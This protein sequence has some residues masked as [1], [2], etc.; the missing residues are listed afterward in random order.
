MKRLILLSFLFIALYPSSFKAQIVNDP[1]PPSN[2][3]FRQLESCPPGC[4]TCSSSEI[5][6]N[7]DTHRT[8]IDGKCRCEPPRILIS[9]NCECPWYMTGNPMT[10]DC[11][12]I[13]LLDVAYQPNISPLFDAVFQAQINPKLKWTAPP[14]FTWTFDCN[15]E[16][17]D[18]Q[19]QINTYLSTQQSDI[20][21]VPS[22]FLEYNLQCE[23]KVSFI[24]QNS[25][26]ISKSV[27]FT[28]TSY[29]QP[30]V[31]IVGGPFQMLNHAHPN[32]ILAEVA[33]LTG[34]P[35]LPSDL[36]VTWT[37][38]SGEKLEMKR[39]FSSLNPLRLTIPKCTLS[40]EKL[41]TF[42]IDV[43]IGLNPVT[44][45][46]EITIGVHAPKI[47][48]E[49]IETSS[50]HIYSQD[51]KLTASR[52]SVEDECKQGL[53]PTDFLD[54]STVKYT[55][56]C[57]FVDLH[58]TSSRRLISTEST[59]ITNDLNAITHP[60]PR[61]LFYRSTTSKTLTIPSSY[62]THY[63]DY[64]FIFYLTT[65]IQSKIPTPSQANFKLLKPTLHVI[66]SKAF[67]QILNSKPFTTVSINCI[68]ENNCQT[69]SDDITQFIGSNYSPKFTYTWTVNMFSGNQIGYIYKNWIT[70]IK[71][72]P[73]PNQKIIPQI[74]LK[75]ADGENVA[76]AFFTMPFR[77][78]LETGSISIYPS[79]GEAYNT[80]FF[81]STY[82]SKDDDLPVTF[83]FYT[84]CAIDR[85]YMLQK[86]EPFDETPILLPPFYGGCSIGVLLTEALGY[87][88]TISKGVPLTGRLTSLKEA[89]ERGYLAMDS[90]RSSSNLYQRLRLI[91]V[92]LQNLQAW[93]I[94]SL[95]DETMNVTSSQFKYSAISE[96]RDI[97][98][99]L[100]SRDDV[101][102]ILLKSIQWSS[103]Q[104]F[105]ED[106]NWRLYMSIIDSSYDLLRPEEYLTFG[107]ILDNLIY[108]MKKPGSTF[109]DPEKVFA[110]ANI[111]SKSAL[112]TL[113][114]SNEQG[115]NFDGVFYA[116]FTIKTT[117]CKVLE[118]LVQ[119]PSYYGLTANFTLKPGKTISPEKCNEP[120]DFIYM[121][122]RPNYTVE[123]WWGEFRTVIAL[124]LRDPVTGKSVIDLYDYFVSSTF[125]FCPDWA[126]LCQSDPDGGTTIY[127]VFDLKDQIYKIFGKSKIDQIVNISALSDF[128]F[129]QSVAFWTVIGFSIWFITSFYWLYIKHPTY[130]VLNA[131]KNINKQPLYKK[132][133]FFFWVR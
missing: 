53:L 125:E 45:S 113:Y 84:D 68:N 41:Y 21:I 91:S 75:V 69:F 90:S 11:E 78:P 55:W 79:E 104:L 98:L 85:N 62:F 132:T 94:S 70:M 58:Y 126:N 35:I 83:Q 121:S 38:M 99:A 10:Q 24:N 48:L 97:S 36:K 7:C 51:L 111:L 29:F 4:R 128:K 15:Y 44:T 43:Q 127:G 13:D 112:S 114:P 46:Q 20:L 93:E 65:T 25:L 19:D 57:V 129:W 100:G 37:Q 1:K 82:L 95:P 77:T 33:S 22:S 107:T 109:A 116:M 26:E 50:Y 32:L 23:V 117:Y 60:D 105:N 123:G 120:I 14:T 80:N 74:I 124:D 67:I 118:N 8:L 17:T 39:V 52:F 9:S 5:C 106:K 133:N 119:V 6:T 16:N 130:C 64:Q 42:K 81:A 92:V 73:N 54:L 27:S 49:P 47:N 87:S 56:E 72:N 12:Y 122:F 34:S 76:S 89:L 110:Y 66:Q 40:P 96:L 103:E 3:S 2:P 101:G 108:Y 63:Q 71:A 61:N 31:R 131:K 86:Y 102:G 88:V 18:T 59:D 28:T 115:F 30:Q